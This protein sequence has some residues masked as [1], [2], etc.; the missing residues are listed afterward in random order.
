[1]TMIF[2]KES[3]E[4]HLNNEQKATARAF[5]AMAENSLVMTIG[6]FRYM[7]HF[8]DLFQQI[9]DQAFGVLAPI[10]KLLLKMIISSNVRFSEI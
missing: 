2:A 7:E 3:M 8:D 6:Y 5:E 10:W 9:P 1:M 4:N